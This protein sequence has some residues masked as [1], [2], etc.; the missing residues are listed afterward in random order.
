V[1]AVCVVCVV[2]VCVCLCVTIL[3]SAC[4]AAVVS[5]GQTCGLY[6]HQRESGSCRASVH[7]Y[8]RMST[9][10][11]FVNVCMHACMYLCM[12]VFVCVFVCVVCVRSLFVWLSIHLRLPLCGWYSSPLVTRVSRHASTHTQTHI[13][14]QVNTQLD[15]HARIS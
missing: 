2:C 3:L 9:Y 10:V 15:T 6:L 4:T 11:L 8:V 1:C 5:V 13:H 14:T 12:C 7:E